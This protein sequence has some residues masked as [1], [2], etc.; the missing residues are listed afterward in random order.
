M[1]CFQGKTNS[2]KFVPVDAKWTLVRINAHE[3]LDSFE[4]RGLTAE[5]DYQLVM[6]VRNQL[7]W[8]DYSS[9][10]FVFH[11]PNGIQLLLFLTVVDSYKLTLTFT[12][13]E[14]YYSKTDLWSNFLVTI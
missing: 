1:L 7:G 11:T 3:P 12:R 13:P 8:S 5:T 9:S 14:L 10:H 4:L 6:K 2:S